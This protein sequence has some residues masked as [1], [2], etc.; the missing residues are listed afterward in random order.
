MGDEEVVRR[1]GGWIEK[2]GKRR[3]EEREWKVGGGGK[4]GAE[5]KLWR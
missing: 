5:L 4:R 3:L 1:R 2:G